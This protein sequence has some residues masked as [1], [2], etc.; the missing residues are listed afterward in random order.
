MAVTFDGSTPPNA[1]MTG[2]DNQQRC[3]NCA[4]YSF[5]VW[6]GDDD[7]E[8]K[9]FRDRDACGR[10]WWVDGLMTCPSFKKDI[11]TDAE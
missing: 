3:W 6:R 10:V 7:T 9:C 4:Y 5:K 2:K 8:G 11:I 1:A